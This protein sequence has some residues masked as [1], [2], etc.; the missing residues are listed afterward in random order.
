MGKE[1]VATLSNIKNWDYLDS[2]K[3]KIP[4]YDPSIPFGLMIGGNCPTALE[5]WQQIHSQDNGPYGKRTALGWCIIGPISSE[6]QKSVKCNYTRMI[7]PHRDVATN[8]VPSHY[9]HVHSHVESK[10]ISHALQEMYVKEFNEVNSEKKA[11]SRED[12]HFLRTMENGISRAGA[13]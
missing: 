7:A 9:F 1:D 13:Q 6:G 12:D 10:E 5:S 4:E 2:I 3:D 8:E 11:P